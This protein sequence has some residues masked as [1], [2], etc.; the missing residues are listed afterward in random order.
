MKLLYTFFIVCLI[1]FYF[2]DQDTGNAPAPAPAP[3]V[4]IPP[5]GITPVSSPE[6][7]RILLLQSHSSPKPTSASRSAVLVWWCGYCPTTTP[8]PDISAS[9]FG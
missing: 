9:S 5:T 3:D 2:L 8:V 4:V 1:A 7:S 6:Q